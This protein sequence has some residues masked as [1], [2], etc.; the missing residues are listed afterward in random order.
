MTRSPSAF[1]KHAVAIV[2]MAGRFPGAETLDAFWDTIRSGSDCFREFSDS[3]L[4]ASGISETLRTDPAYV[5]GGTVLEDADAFD[6]AYF[7]ISPREAQILDPQHRILLECAVSAMED[8]GYGAATDAVVGVYAG[9]SMN[10]YLIAQIL[11]D[12]AL[13][14]SVGGYQLMLGNDK[15]F[16][17]TRVSYKLNLKGPSLTIQ[18]ACSTSLVA[19]ATACQALTRGECDMALAGGV[20]VT[21]PQH[22]GYLYQE[23]M[24]LSPDGRCRPFDLDARGTRPGAGAGIVVLKRLA[25]AI[26][27]RDTIHAVI[28][29]AALNNDGA[30][31]AGYTAPSIDGQVEVISMA[32]SL[33]D[34]DPRTIGYVEAH[35]TGTPLGDP[36]EIAALTAAFRATT[37]DVGFCR[38]GSLKANLGHLDTAA[39][40]AGLIKTVLVLKNGYLPPL[41][42]FWSPNPQL[43]LGRSPFVASNEGEAW[44]SLAE[45]RRAGVSS[46]GIG[47][48]NA[49]AVLEEAPPV[50]MRDHDE[51]DQ[52]IILSARTDTALQTASVNLAD[53]LEHNDALPL[54]DAAWTLQVGRTPHPYRRAVVARSHSEA[55]A[56]LRSGA[57]S[58]G[59]KHEGNPRPVAFLFS[60]QGSQYR[61]MG[62]E[63]YRTEPVY[64]SAI[65]RC[66]DLLVP[67]LGLDVRSVLFGDVPSDL[68]RQTS[69]AQPAL[70]ATSYALAQLWRAWGVIPC[71]MMGHSIGEYVAAELA[72]VMSLEDAL[73]VVAARG[74][75]MQALPPGGMAAVQLSADELRVH[76]SDSVTIAAINAPRMCT[77][78]GATE[79]LAENVRQ[80]RAMGIEARTLHTSHAFHSPMMEPVLSE[81]TDVLAR[82]SLQEPRI[83]YVSN[84]TGTWITP[85]QA[86]SPSYYAAHLRQAVQFG[87]GLR[88]LS[89]E[90]NAFLLELGPGNNLTTFAQ[91][92]LD[93]ISARY[94]ASS[95]PHPQSPRS[96]RATM[97]EAAGRIWVAGATVDWH[98]LRGD[99]QVYRVP[100]PTYPF[101]RQ[102]YFV[103]AGSD[104]P[105]PA[106]D[107]TVRA[108][109]PTW[110]LA[111]SATPARFDGPWLIVGGSAVMGEAVVAA[112]ATAGIQALRVEGQTASDHASEA[113][114]RASGSGNNDLAGVVILPGEANAAP[115]YSELVSVAQSLETWGRTEPLRVIVATLRTQSVLRE[116][117]DPEAQLSL[118]PVLVLPSELPGLTMRTVDFDFEARG[119]DLPDFAR[120]VVQ[121]VQQGDGEPVV[122][123][124]FGQRFVRRFDPVVLPPAREASVRLR[125]GGTYLITGGLGGIGLT[126]ASWLG[127]TVGA[128]LLLTARTPLP[129]RET[130]RAVADQPDASIRD[131]AAIAAIQEIEARGGEVMVAVADAGDRE[132]MSAAITAAEQRWGP[133]CGVIHAAGVPG[134]GVVAARLNSEDVAATLSPKVDGL[135]IL[136]E[137]LGR[138]PL[139]FVALMSSINSVVGAA[140]ACDYTAANAFLDAFADGGSRPEAW[141]RVVSI[142]W[143]A[144]RD[145]G[146]AANLVVPPSRRAAWRVRQASAIRSADGVEAFAQVIASDLFRVVIAPFDVQAAHMRFR[147]GQDLATTREIEPHSTDLPTA[148]QNRSEDCQS[149]SGTDAEQTLR[150]IWSDLLGIESIG[151]DDDFFALGGHSLLAT[152]VLSRIDESLHVRLTL[153][154][155]FEAP[156]V[157]SLANLVKP[158]GHDV[159]EAYEEREEFVI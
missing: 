111:S 141:R 95:L 38:L 17:C 101:E 81:F 93:P 52:L 139:D 60:G 61:S 100:L 40:V 153:R 11:R 107:T 83:P 82:V 8:A 72:G 115:G 2:G 69:L 50:P 120:A 105:V 148:G 87:P 70:F 85:E 146:M 130:W 64:E 79:A 91:L 45:P 150:R 36:I 33:A 25:D 20:S 154:D 49:H 103:E 67:H 18:T 140:G 23:G 44:A 57:G 131:L 138:T 54:A 132:A 71:A 31:K 37:N 63:L 136:V 135:R 21:F 125:R 30:D 127:R 75:L 66:A 99:R 76:L 98:G 3:E 59:T 149:D 28:R 151:L 43:D 147:A 86:T 80:L 112:F 26:A 134:R 19:V 9:A 5:R 32:H 116:P 12:R 7:G 96:E 122:A 4:A 145:V 42:H 97:L 152:R 84:V 102:R 118:G 22:S 6:A 15:D 90:T 117:A 13:V 68:L 65:D 156:T 108:F 121:E 92:V 62:G 129:P 119:S 78:S 88:V 109:V 110:S 143:S 1:P 29:G 46:F 74:Q 53:F 157:R 159:V 133:I 27:D 124:R 39:G 142:N 123:N 55:A 10:T 56:A 155:L 158:R 48:T 104:D 51:R 41:C 94:A 114:I 73:T 24:I 35:G 14:D 106:A 126:L 58:A 137:L 34:I 89:A 47:G 77:I 128:R 16:L 144:W 113:P